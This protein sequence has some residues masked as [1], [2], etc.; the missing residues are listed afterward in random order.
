M[1]TAAIPAYAAPENPPSK[2]ELCLDL[3]AWF[4][5]LN[6]N[7]TASAELFVARYGLFS[8]ESAAALGLPARI[9]QTSQ[10]A[11]ASLSSDMLGATSREQ[12]IVVET[13][14]ER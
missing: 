6:L 1:T 11:A 12:V 10:G 4:P 9:C 3:P 2:G 7:L 8:M 5:Q 14:S 13:P